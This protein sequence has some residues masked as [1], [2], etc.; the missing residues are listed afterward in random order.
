MNGTIELLD[1]QEF[2]QNIRQ[3]G[4]S[5]RMINHA[6]AAWGEI[7]NRFESG[8]LLL[9]H[10]L[11]IEHYHRIWRKLKGSSTIQATSPLRKW[12]MDHTR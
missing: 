2:E 7:M 9:E 3:F 12:T 8:E 10:Q 1:E 11:R 4:Y 5:P 6:R